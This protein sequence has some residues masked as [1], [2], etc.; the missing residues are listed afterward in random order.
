[1]IPRANYRMDVA[2][3]GTVVVY[4]AN[5]GGRSVTNDAEAVLAEIDAR[6][7]LGKRL[8]IYRDTEGTF[9][10]LDHENGA[11]K[12]FYPLGRTDLRPALQAAR[13]RRDILAACSAGEAQCLDHMDWP[14]ARAIM[15]VGNLM[16]AAAHRVIG[17]DRFDASFRRVRDAAE[18]FAERNRT[19][20]RRRRDGHG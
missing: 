16:D 12:G 11:F 9:D 2:E 5:D 18:D 14:T 6:I 15:F 8:V 17:S 10:G 1:M 4:D 3:D 7:G 19:T 20:S 13:L